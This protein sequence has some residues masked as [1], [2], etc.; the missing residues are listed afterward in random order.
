MDN[1][2]RFQSFNTTRNSP[3]NLNTNMP[4][5]PPHLLRNNVN[6]NPFNRGVVSGSFN[7]V[8][9]PPRLNNNA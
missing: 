5:P 4:M 8:P 7:R 3:V 2:T 6:T 1:I 9:P